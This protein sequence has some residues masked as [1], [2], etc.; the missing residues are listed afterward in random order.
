MK[1]SVA[2][3]ALNVSPIV[4]CSLVMIDNIPRAA[5]AKTKINKIRYADDRCGVKYIPMTD[6]M[7]AKYQNLHCLEVKNVVKNAEIGSNS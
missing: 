1:I 6:S 2:I 4:I 3:G 5:E 7:P